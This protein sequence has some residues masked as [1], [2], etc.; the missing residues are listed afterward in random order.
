MDMISDCRCL[1]RKG[2]HTQSSIVYLH[3][4][5]CLNEIRS[6]V[7]TQ[8]GRL[9]TGYV[10]YFKNKLKMQFFLVIF[11]SFTSYNIIYYLKIAM[12]CF[13]KK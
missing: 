3:N 8:Q 2:L 1:Y 10:K 13:L 12:F 6:Q 11:K 7:L 4:R 5:I 9:F